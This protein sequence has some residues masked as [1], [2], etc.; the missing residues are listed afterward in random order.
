MDFKKEIILNNFSEKERKYGIASTVQ[1]W[2][3]RKRGKEK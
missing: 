3:K 1:R 2:K